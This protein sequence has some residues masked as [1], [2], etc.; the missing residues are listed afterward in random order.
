MWFNF[1]L[2]LCIKWLLKE[3]CVKVQ[4]LVTFTVSH[5]VHSNKEVALLCPS[6]DNCILLKFHWT[7]CWLSWQWR[8]WLQRQ[9]LLRS[10]NT[11]PGNCIF[12]FAPQVCQIVWN[13]DVQSRLCS[14]MSTFSWFRRKDAQEMLGVEWTACTSKNVSFLADLSGVYNIEKFTVPLI[15][16]Y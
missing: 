2:Y 13:R 9:E 10:N 8:Q 1:K 14:V 16:C 5:Y 11:H 12:C 4:Y 15:F 7:T 3:W 6:H